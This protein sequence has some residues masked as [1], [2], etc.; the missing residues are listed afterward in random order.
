MTMNTAP[1][2]TSL[3]SIED[4]QNDPIAPMIK[5]KTGSD[6][7]YYPKVNRDSELLRE[8]A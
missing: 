6:L 2:D 4:L 3:I 8:E 1:N 7:I 5:V